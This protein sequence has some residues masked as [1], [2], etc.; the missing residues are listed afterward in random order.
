M[1]QLRKVFQILPGK[2]KTTLSMKPDEKD[3]KLLK[4]ISQVAAGFTLIVA[5]TMLFSLIQLKTIDPL[6]NPIVASVK[7]QYDRD[8]SDAMLAEQ[9]RAVDLMA[10]RAYFSSRWQVE[11]GSYLLLAGAVVFIICQRLIA[12]SRKTAPVKPG[13]KPDLPRQNRFVI[14]GLMVTGTL[15]FAAALISSFAMRGILP[16]TLNDRRLA[17][18]EEKERVRSRRTGSTEAFMADPTNYPFF[19]GQDG[20]GIAGGEGYPTEWDGAEGKNIKWKTMIPKMGKSSPVIWG[21]K[22]FV[23]GAEGKE[24]EV[25]CIDKK[26]GEI[27]WTV[28]AYDIPGEPDIIPEMDYDAGMAVSTVATNGTEV[29]AVFANGNLICTDTDGRIKWSKN[30]GLPEN[31]YGYSSSLIIYDDVLIVQFDSDEKI[32]L[33]GFDVKSGALKWETPRQGYPSWASPVIASFNG[34]PH[35]L[36]NSNPYVT[37]Y[38]PVTG[39]QL[40]AVEAMYGDVAPSC[41]VNSSMVYAVTDYAKLAAIRPGEGAS[42]VWEDNTFTPDVSS[43]VANEEFLFI[44]TGYGDVAC[45]N[46]QNGDTLWTRMLNEPFYASPIIADNMVYILDRS[47]V[48]HIVRA[49]ADYQLISRSPIGERADCTPAFSDRE[50]YIRAREN[51]YCISES[52]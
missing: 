36:I 6:D 20:R 31:I 22:I 8:P 29:C 18:G 27:V 44:V 23:T 14:N 43:P 32:S 52:E 42:I 1:F 46:A 15:L 49:S 19:R 47:G 13:E 48:M 12:G 21:D 2:T 51:L 30:I 34:Q 39:A 11:T 24:C 16:D 40:W 33:L 3:I 50:I 45:Y 26:T 7:E 9:V 10:R 25:Y 17:G 41:A 38:D 5:F 28:L 35:V 4:F 37:G